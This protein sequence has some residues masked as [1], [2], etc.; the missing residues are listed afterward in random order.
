M[1]S[2]YGSRTLAKSSCLPDAAFVIIPRS[3]VFLNILNNFYNQKSVNVTISNGIQVLDKNG[4]H[5]ELELLSSGEKQLLLLVCNILVSTSTPSIFIIDEPEL[6]LNIKWQ[7]KIVDSLLAL[8]KGGSMQFIMATH[9]IE[10][11]TRHKD[12]VLDLID[13]SEIS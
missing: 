5:L 8:A 3:S 10:L 13:V 9:S 4:D 11:L 1:L 7:R 6:S 2:T 12:R